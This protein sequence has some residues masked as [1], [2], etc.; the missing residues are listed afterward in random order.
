MQLRKLKFMALK[1]LADLK[2]KGKSVEIATDLTSPKLGMYYILFG[3]NLSSLNRLIKGFDENGIP[4]NNAYIDVAGGK[5]HYYPISIG[6]VGL[7]IF[8]QYVTHQDPYRLKEFLRIADWFVDNKSEDETMGTYWLTEVPKPEYQVDSPWKSAFTQSRALSILLRAWQATGEPHYLQIASNALRPFE[9]DIA[10]GGVAIRRKSEEVFY[11][12]YVARFPT[13]VLDGHIFALFGLYDYVRAVDHTEYVSSRELAHRL[14]DEGISGL[15]EALPKFD[16]GYWVLFNRCQVPG[17]P[18]FD[19]CTINYLQLVCTQLDIL[20][21]ITGRNEL[22]KYRKKF[23][24]YQRWPNIIKMY[25]AK[26]KAL[27]NLNRL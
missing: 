7:A 6:Q 11:E 1:L 23:S 26:F 12:E 16:L 27:K 25:I 5:P 13:R 17:Y 21:K 10:D 3:S 18:K 15:I 24:N 22:E 8:H 4:I 2:T 19:P 9:H 20:Y 14:F